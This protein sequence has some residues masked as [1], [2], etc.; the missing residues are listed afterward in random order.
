MG[1]NKEL[2]DPSPKYQVTFVSLVI[3]YM[4]GKKEIGVIPTYPVDELTEKFTKD[5]II[6]SQLFLQNKKDPLLQ[7]GL[8][9]KLHCSVMDI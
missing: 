3:G 2:E 7:F 5:I 1:Y 4:V 8:P 9:N 6:K